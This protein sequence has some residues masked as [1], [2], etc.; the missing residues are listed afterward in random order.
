MSGQV[1]LVPFLV[2]L[3]TAVSTVVEI[4]VGTRSAGGIEDGLPRG[5]HQFLMH[6]MARNSLV[7]EMLPTVA[8]RFS[9]YSPGKD[10]QL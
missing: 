5:E 7:S 1:E 6:G 2:T 8:Y 4:M 9:P 3:P 10:D